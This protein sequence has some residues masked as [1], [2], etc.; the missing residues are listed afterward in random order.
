MTAAE[1]SELVGEVLVVFDC[2]TVRKVEPK[3]T[4]N[5]ET[6]TKTTRTETAT[7]RFTPTALASLMRFLHF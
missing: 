4:V 3:N 5:A 2:G 7:I 1:V 6:K